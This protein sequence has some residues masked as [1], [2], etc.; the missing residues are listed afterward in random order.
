[1][2]AEQASLSTIVID[3]SGNPIGQVIYR[4]ALC[5]KICDTS[6]DAM[7]H[8]HNDHIETTKLQLQQQQLQQTSQHNVGS[9]S[10]A[11]L[12]SAGRNSSVATLNHTSPSAHY[13]H[14]H[15]NQHSNS[16]TRQL[17]NP[18]SYTSSS[19]LKRAAASSGQGS[20]LKRTS[21]SSSAS[22]AASNSLLKRAS[23]VMRLHQS[24]TSK[25]GS[26]KKPSVGNS[27]KSEP[28]HRQYTTTSASRAAKRHGAA[29]AIDS[30]KSQT[31]VK[32][33][34]S[35]SQQTSLQTP[36]QSDKK[37]S[38]RPRSISRRNALTS[39]LKARSRDAVSLRHQFE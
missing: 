16:S 35:E 22:T 28:I 18:S 26:N 19:L 11:N 3:G 37:Y 25:S 21:S 6:S 10:L 9:T 15:H 30:T 33:P 27:T 24:S 23:N 14:H 34:V 38:L 4:C 13:I 36:Q 8:Y 32:Q 17:T 39:P 29:T 12:N 20:L 7:L 2:E 31:P 5:R 1:M